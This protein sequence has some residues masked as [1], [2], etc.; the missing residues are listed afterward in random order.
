MLPVIILERDT[1]LRGALWDA[2]AEIARVCV[3]DIR[4]S[5]STD[6]LAEAQKAARDEEGSLLLLIGLSSENVDKA[7]LL[8]QEVL[9]RCRDSYPVFS[10]RQAGVLERMLRVCPRPAGI[11]LPPITQDRIKAALTGIFHDYTELIR[12]RQE[13]LLLDFGTSVRRLPRDIV[14]HIE[15]RDKKVIIYTARQCF[16][17]YGTITD[18]E[19]KLERSFLRC[20]RA[21]L[22]NPKLIESVDF[23]ALSI[24]MQ[25][26]AFVPIA[27]ARREDFRQWAAAENHSRSENDR[28]SECET[29]QWASSIMTV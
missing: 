19:S 7:S 3:C 20:H 15:A 18:M 9:E 1:Q 29:Q 22:V 12:P 28:S 25:G 21:F 8:A 11:M 2:V 5:M 26:G 10:V 13:Q 16:S 24:T 4:L 14:T 23:T 27:R 6:K 17:V